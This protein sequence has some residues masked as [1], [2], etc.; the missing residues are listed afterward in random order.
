MNIEDCILTTY[1]TVKPYDSIKSIEELLKK[2]D[3]LV[4]EDEKNRF[5]GILTPSDILARPHKLVIDC[6]TPKRIIHT[7][8][9]FIELV[10]KFDQTPSEALP[11]FQNE[12]YLGI[13]EKSSAIKKLK[14]T[15]DELRKELI[16]SQK[17]KNEFL[18]N[19]SH[20]VRT[21]L[22]Q[23]LGFMS[24]VSELSPEEIEPNREQY[25]AIIKKSSEEF[26]SVMDELI[27]LSR[28]YS[29]D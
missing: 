7:N 26:L 4:V 14:F 25:Y 5:F 8:D 2:R 23:I 22:N 9:S 27:E 19:L 29:E 11:V 1:P 20:E 28:S 12:E 16:L 17:A 3:Y 10:S 15:I 24:L 13:L 6:L 21:P 18:H